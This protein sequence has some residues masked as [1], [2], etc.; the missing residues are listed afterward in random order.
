[1][2]HEL[3][4]SF[5]YQKKNTEVVLRG[6]VDRLATSFSAEYKNEEPLEWLGGWD[7]DRAPRV[8]TLSKIQLPRHFYGI[9]G[10]IG[11]KNLKGAAYDTLEEFHKTVDFLSASQTIS[12]GS[13]T[14]QRSLESVV[15]SVMRKQSL[16]NQKWILHGSGIVEELKYS[17][18]P[19][20]HDEG[21]AYSLELTLLDCRMVHKF[22]VSLG[23]RLSK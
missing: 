17:L 6:S 16:G 19:S 20:A 14:H 4:F 7:D 10:R 1:M 5:P 8:E 21:Y 2:A 23:S 3:K 15:V 9:K 12:G 13:R 18:M 22:A 11:P